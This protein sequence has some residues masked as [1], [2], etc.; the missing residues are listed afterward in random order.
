MA[1]H[2]V[3]IEERYFSLYFVEKKSGFSP[4]LSEINLVLMKPYLQSV[5]KRPLY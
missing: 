4:L 3:L 2:Q 1:L 5:E